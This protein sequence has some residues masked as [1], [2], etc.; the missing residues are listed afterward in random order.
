MIFD[1]RELELIDLAEWRVTQA[2]CLRGF[3][4][5]LLL[6]A[7]VF[8]SAGVLTAEML[9]GVS[10]GLVLVAICCP[11]WGPVRPRYS[12]LV[13]LLVRKRGES[14]NRAAPAQTFA[15]DAHGD[16]SAMPSSILNSQERTLSS[17][18]N[19]TSV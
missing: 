10:V 4:L 5:V 9:A 13:D 3:C 8:Y 14:A 19:S 12:E 15:L 11:Q 7:V 1:K 17:R 18:T 2:L 16:H 6:H